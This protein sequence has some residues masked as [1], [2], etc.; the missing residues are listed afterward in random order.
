MHRISHNLLIELKKKANLHEN[1]KI[2]DVDCSLWSDNKKFF[3]YF[4]RMYWRFKID[5]IDKNR[6][7]TL[8]FGVILNF[9]NREC[10]CLVSNNMFYPLFKNELRYSQAYIRILQEIINHIKNF[11][12]IHAGVVSYNGKGV[13]IVGPPSFGKTTLTLE[14]VKRGFKFLSDEFCPFHLTER[15]VYPFPRCISLRR[16]IGGSLKGIPQIN[17]GENIDFERE[18]KVL[19]DIEEWEK[20]SIGDVVE[21]KYVFFLKGKEGYQSNN[22]MQLIDI[23]SIKDDEA[24]LSEMYTISGVEILHMSD[25]G[26]YRV[27]R[28]NCKRGRDI[29]YRL[30]EIL[31]KYRENIFF[32]EFI[33]SDVPEFNRNPFFKPLPPSEAVNEL[34]RNITNHSRTSFIMK[35]FKS[36]VN[37]FYNLGGIVKEMGCYEL[38]VGRLKK[39]AELIVNI[40]EG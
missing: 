30:K 28:L 20:E 6:E 19:I 21:A 4:D 34:F 24:L 8:D 11:L 5:R 38:Y 29:N 40:I 14:L 2:L 18:K 32:T 1:Y 10:P 12:L 17:L 27:Y 13:L 39:M 9:F 23:A 25:K 15:R 22:G 35:N 7:N 31:G 16:D 3:D 33:T 36:S 37:L 26:S